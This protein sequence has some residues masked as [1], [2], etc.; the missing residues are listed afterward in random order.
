MS[1][2]FPLLAVFIISMNPASAQ[3]NIQTKDGGNVSIGPNGISVNKRNKKID[4]SPAGINIEKPGKTVEVT[5][6]GVK[7]SKNKHKKADKDD[8]EAVSGAGSTSLSVNAGNL[9]LDQRI[10]L[11]EMHVYGKKSDQP[12]MHR[13]EKL[14]R[15]NF[16]KKGS[17]TIVQRID[18]LWKDLAPPATPQDST[19]NSGIG[20]GS[21][22]LELSKKD[23]SQVLTL[24]NSNFEG[25]IK[26]QNNDAILN[27]SNCKIKFLGPLRKLV[28]N[29]SNNE[30]YC[31]NILEI[32]T[33]GSG[34]DVSWSADM[35]P[36]G[37]DA[38]TS[39]KLHAKE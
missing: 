27:A 7:T 14:E 37:A 24:N 34:N 21:S 8:T 38:G 11:I 4:I 10:T 12:L 39:N 19:I 35:K 26:C 1:R 36:S 16:G 31:E 32:Q 29:G 20:I 3:F 22:P 15:D 25:E 33:N 23:D 13:V 6:D 30:I 17:G 2:L 18:A 9:S 5:P 28:V